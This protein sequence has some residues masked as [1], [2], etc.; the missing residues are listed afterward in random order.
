MRKKLRLFFEVKML[1]KLL[2]LEGRNLIP[3]R[4]L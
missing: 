2:K 3:G 4:R 1:W